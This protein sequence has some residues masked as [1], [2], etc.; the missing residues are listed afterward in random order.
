MS[1]QTLCQADDDDSAIDSSLKS[2]GLVLGA[3]NRV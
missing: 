2:M 3:G 1:N